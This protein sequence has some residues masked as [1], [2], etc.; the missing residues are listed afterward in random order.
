[1]TTNYDLLREFAD[2]WG[3]LAMLVMFLGIVIFTFRPGSRALHRDMAHLPL[4]NDEA[5]KTLENS[6]G[7]RQ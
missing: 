1:M 5:P 3:L 4:R 6:E 2:S 7:G